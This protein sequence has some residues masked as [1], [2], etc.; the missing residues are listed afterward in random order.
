MLIATTRL[1][2]YGCCFIFMAD[3]FSI[4]PF[5][6]LFIQMHYHYC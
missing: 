2:T 5:F 1:T 3:S 4:L 6:I